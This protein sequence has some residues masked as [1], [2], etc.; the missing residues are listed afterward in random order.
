MCMCLPIS[1]SVSIEVQIVNVN[2]NLVGHTLFWMFLQG[3]FW[4]SL[5]FKYV[6]LNIA[7]GPP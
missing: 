2:V 3:C 1:I 6:T 5:T 4:M 7:D